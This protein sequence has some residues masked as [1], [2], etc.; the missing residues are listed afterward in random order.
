[1]GN[2]P[3][4]P[5]NCEIDTSEKAMDCMKECK[6]E[7][8]CVE[9]QKCIDKKHSGP[10]CKNNGCDKCKECNEKCKAREDFESNDF[11]WIGGRMLSPA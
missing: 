4:C 7:P 8:E 3:E 9:C 10:K 11:A 6:E 1:M 2:C 5:K